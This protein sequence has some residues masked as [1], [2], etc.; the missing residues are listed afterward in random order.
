M[1]EKSSKDVKCVVCGEPAVTTVGGLPFCE[2]C[3]DSE[4][5]QEAAEQV[6]I[7]EEK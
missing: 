5:A 2:L 7:F 1:I 3:K 4:R 6:S